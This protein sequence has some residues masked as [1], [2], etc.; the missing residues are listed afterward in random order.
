M[1]EHA[2]PF[3]IYLKDLLSAF[4]TIETMILVS[5]KGFQQFEMKVHFREQTLNAATGK[6]HFIV[7][8]GNLY[9]L[10]TSI[11]FIPTNKKPEFLPFFFFLI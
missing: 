10:L 4:L 5:H 6:I 3:H 1:L 2:I 11:Y 9:F 8:L 7:Q